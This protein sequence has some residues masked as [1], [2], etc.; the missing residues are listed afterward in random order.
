ME[1]LHQAELY[2]EL[3]G[4]LEEF[5]ELYIELREHNSVDYSVW[6]ALSY[7]YGAYVAD[8]LEIGYYPEELQ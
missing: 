3:Q 7:L 5:I 8:M 6:K 4:N 1:Y 2:A